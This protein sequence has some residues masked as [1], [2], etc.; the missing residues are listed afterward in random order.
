MIAKHNM[1]PLTRTEVNF[2]VNRLTDISLLGKSADKL[3]NVYVNDNSIEDLSCLS[4]ASELQ[5]LSFD[6]NRVKTID[7]LKNCF[8]LCGVSGENNKIK[9]I[10]SLKNLKTLQYIYFP[11]NEISD[12]SAISSLSQD[13]LVLDLSSNNV[14]KLMLHAS[15]K[16]T[17]LSI[18]N[19]PLES[20]EGIEL[21]SGYYT[22]FSYID[23]N[24]LDKLHDRFSYGITI[25]DCPLDQQ[26]NV[27]DTI[28]KYWVTF[29]TLQETEEFIHK[30]KQSVL[31]GKTDDN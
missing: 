8:K 3:Q 7:A 5:Y 28:G 24:Y 22:I 27:E 10:E 26:V 12:M 14:S 2:N 9:S 31:T 29:S 13:I 23:N 25:L 11:H 4:N 18:Y 17:Y 19:N 16:Y 30:T 1:N 15:S 21:V 20:L 6:N